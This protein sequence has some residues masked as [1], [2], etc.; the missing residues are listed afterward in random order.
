M[1][2]R[3]VRRQVDALLAL[4]EELD[5][6]TETFSPDGHTMLQG[7]LTAMRSQLQ[8]FG[9]VV[10]DSLAEVETA[11]EAHDS[12]A[13]LLEQVHARSQDIQH[14]VRRALTDQEG[15]WEA[16]AAVLEAAW[17]QL[18]KVAHRAVQ[19]LVTRSR[20]PEP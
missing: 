19:E 12:L 9:A 2:S 18:E 7:A 8:A 10:E 14:H 1:L 3:E 13:R 11:N 20:P 5:R 16:R 4:I 15:D 17:S 6:T